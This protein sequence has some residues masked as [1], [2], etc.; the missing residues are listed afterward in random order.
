MHAQQCVCACS[1]HLWSEFLISVFLPAF[2]SC[3][4]Q[5]ESNGVSKQQ[6]LLQQQQQAQYQQVCSL[7]GSCW[8]TVIYV[9]SVQSMQHIRLRT[10]ACLLVSGLSD[11]CANLS[12]I[13]LRCQ[14]KKIFCCTIT[15]GLLGL[16][17][18]VLGRAEQSSGKSG[19]F[20]QLIKQSHARTA[21]FSFVLQYTC[22]V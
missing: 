21:A 4:L 18:Y 12:I 9:H 17:Q 8:S 22:I 13:V 15:Y 20:V 10:S 11:S 2:V 16:E 1:I 14:F 3:S 7:V 6:E 19:K 5:R